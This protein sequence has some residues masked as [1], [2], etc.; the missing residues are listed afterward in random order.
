MR[1]IT[2][3][4]LGLLVAVIVF[5]SSAFIAKKNATLI[6]YY[7][8]NMLYP[9]PSDY[10]GYYYYSSD[11]C[12]AGGNICTAVWNIGP[13]PI[14]TTDGTALPSTGVTY[15]TGSVIVGHFE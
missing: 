1:N 10:R 13:N 2:K 7:K 11:H 4:G 14:P 15:Q 3:T 9:S 12:E 6:T 8:T 5:G